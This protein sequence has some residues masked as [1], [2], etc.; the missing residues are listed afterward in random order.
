MVI[1][2][3]PSRIA[4]PRIRQQLSRGLQTISVSSHKQQV[5]KNAKTIIYSA[6]VS[7]RPQAVAVERSGECLSRRR[8]FSASDA[9]AGGGTC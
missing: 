6:A 2:L 4:V 9:E 8:V 3:V 5:D 7:I 1:I